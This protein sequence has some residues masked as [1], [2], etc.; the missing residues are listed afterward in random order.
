MQ[1]SDMSFGIDI[2]IWRSES[3]HIGTAWKVLSSLKALSQ[4]S[5]AQQCLCFGV[6]CVQYFEV[7]IRIGKLTWTCLTCF[8]LLWMLKNFAFVRHGGL[9]WGWEFQ[10]VILRRRISQSCRM[11]DWMTQPRSADSNYTRSRQGK[12]FCKFKAQR[13]KWKAKKD[14]EEAYAWRVTRFPESSTACQFKETCNVTSNEMK[15]AEWR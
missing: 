10:H 15:C 13:A 4:N 12:N 2:G 9:P 5:S 14:A 1:H 8:N 7:T 11:W 3:V 6:F